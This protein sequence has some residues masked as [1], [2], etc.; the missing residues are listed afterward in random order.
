MLTPRLMPPKLNH[1]RC[2]PSRFIAVGPRQSAR[3]TSLWRVPAF[4]ATRA[5]NGRYSPLWRAISL[6]SRKTRER[7]LTDSKRS[8]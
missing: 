2:Q 3:T 6:P 4:S 7:W 8:A 5:S 1:S